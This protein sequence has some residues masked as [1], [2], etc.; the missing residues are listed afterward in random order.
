MLTQLQSRVVPVVP[1]P[2]TVLMLFLVL[3]YPK[4]SFVRHYVKAPGAPS[5]EFLPV[6]VVQSKT[7]GRLPGICLSRLLWTTMT[8]RLEGLTPPRVLVQTTLQCDMLIGCERTAEDTLV[9]SGMD[10]ALGA[11]RNLMFLTALPG[12]TRMQVV[13]EL[14]L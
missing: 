1:C 3:I 11:L 2:V 12:A 10:L 5:T 9:I 4:I 13:L 7:A 6:R 14:R 8:M